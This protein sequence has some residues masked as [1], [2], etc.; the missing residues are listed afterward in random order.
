MFI[1]VKLTEVI[2]LK[3][4]LLTPF[5]LVIIFFFA[6]IVRERFI[7]NKEIKKYFLPALGI[8][9]FG[10]IS[11]GLIY[12][13]YYRGGDTMAYF[14]YSE[15]IYELF[16]TNFND[17]VRLVFLD[18]KD[19]PLDLMQYLISVEYAR[20]PASYFV[21]RVGAVLN[22]FSFGTY[23]TTACFFAVI[24][25]AGVWSFFT[26]VQKI[27]PHLTKQL[28][29]ATFFIPSTFFWGSGILKDSITFAALG[30]AFSSFYN[31]FIARRK[32]L[33]NLIALIVFVYIMKIVK[34]Y[35]VLCFL[36]SAIIWLYLA[37]NSKIKSKLTRNFLIPFQLSLGIA[38]GLYGAYLVTI[39]NHSYSIDK[40][41]ETAKT[42]STWLAIVSKDYGGS[43]YDLGD[44]DPTITGMLAK[45]HLAIWVTLFRPYLWEAKNV[46]ILVSAFESIFF[47]WITF[48][49]IFRLGLSK[50]L[51]VIKSNPFVFF[52]LIFSIVFAFAVGISTFNFGSLVRYKIPLIP[53][54]LSAIYILRS[55][56]KNR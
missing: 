47:L 5:V 34:V 55:K 24:S 56:I 28:A 22:L 11:M 20:D 4:Y 26:T 42:T 2:T 16:F 38:V 8:K 21:V 50:T 35:V 32:I 3:D 6:L 41:G 23:L 44:F 53:F 36:P 27:Y 49:T 12:E 39:D 31:C 48:N 54:Y 40:L 45:A 1:S 9:I 7:Q 29:L 51:G 18:N 10:A 46:L 13:Y 37:Y 19:I 43:Y 25:F 15:I 52:S 14:R 33:R 30:F 17:A